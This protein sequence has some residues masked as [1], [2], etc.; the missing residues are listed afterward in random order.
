MSTHTHPGHE[1]E[2]GSAWFPLWKMENKSK[3]LPIKVKAAV[4]EKSRQLEMKDL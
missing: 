3:L 1:W 4:F 2:S